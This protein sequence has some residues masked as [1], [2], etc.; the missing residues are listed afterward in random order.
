MNKT[1]QKESRG[2]TLIEILIAL[3]VVGILVAVA[4]PSYRDYVTR[5]KLSEATDAVVPMQMELGQACMGKY[6]ANATN[7]SLK[8]RSPTSYATKTAVQSISVDGVSASLAKITVKLNAF[9]AV[10]SGASLIY[11]GSC[12]SSGGLNWKI[13][14][15]ST[16]QKQYQP[17][18]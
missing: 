16:L 1:I 6:L 15:S 18:V 4:L 2:F 12:S 10:Q 8:L 17:R 9:G 3:A 13:D 7:S 11:A 5:S 14:A